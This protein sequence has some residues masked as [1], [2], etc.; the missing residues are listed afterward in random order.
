MILFNLEGYQPI[1]T[2]NYRTSLVS[3]EKSIFINF[4]TLSIGAEEHSSDTNLTC[5]YI[6]TFEVCSHGEVFILGK[7]DQS[8]QLRDIIFIFGDVLS[9]V[10]LQYWQS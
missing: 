6:Y 1:F 4:V 2:F 7:L 8:T 5:A 10:T 9:D 3:G